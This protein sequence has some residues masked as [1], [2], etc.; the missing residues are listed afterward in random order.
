M[1]D[2]EPEPLRKDGLGFLTHSD[3]KIINVGC[4]QLLSFGYFLIW[5][6]VNDISSLNPEEKR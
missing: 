3:F 1:T 6:Y 4:L 5:Q 2:H